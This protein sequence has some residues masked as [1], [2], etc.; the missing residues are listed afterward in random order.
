MS[1][2]KNSNGPL[3]YT[4]TIVLGLKN[5]TLLLF[6]FESLLKLLYVYLSS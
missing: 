4:Y 2:E 5:N 6:C 3:G 1:Y